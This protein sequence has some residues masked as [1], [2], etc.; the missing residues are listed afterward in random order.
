MKFSTVDQ[1]QGSLYGAKEATARYGLSM[2]R[3]TFWQMSFVLLRKKQV[4]R[5]LV[6]RSMG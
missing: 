3:L 4:S 1:T 5:K 6:V 2:K